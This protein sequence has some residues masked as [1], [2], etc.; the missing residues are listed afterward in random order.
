MAAPLGGN[1]CSRQLSAYGTGAED[2]GIDVQKL[3]GLGPILNTRRPSEYA[4][5]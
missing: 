2:A 3:H 4:P 5:I 1:D